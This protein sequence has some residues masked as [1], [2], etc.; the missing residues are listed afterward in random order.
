MQLFIDLPDESSCLCS[1]GLSVGPQELRGCGLSS[2]AGGVFNWRGKGGGGGGGG[3]RGGGG[4]GGGG[5]EDGET[6][7]SSLSFCC[8]ESP[9]V[10]KIWTGVSAGEF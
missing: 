5:G 3:N 8:S 10:T 6:T 4:G 7:G 9:A 2:I 1:A